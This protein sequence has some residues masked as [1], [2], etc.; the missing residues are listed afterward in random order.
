MPYYNDYTPR[1]NMGATSV[2]LSRARKGP[3][4]RKM[5]LNLY[6]DYRL[7]ITFHVVLQKLL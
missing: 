3:N 6:Y 1:D 4:I 2:S 5:T 7:C